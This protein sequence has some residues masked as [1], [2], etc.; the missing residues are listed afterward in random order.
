MISLGGAVLASPLAALGQERVWRLGWLDPN[1]A[2]A[3]GQ[4]Y[5]N[6]DTF[7]K[8]LADLGYVE[9]RNY[10]VESRFADTDNSRL[11]ALAKDLVARGVD[12]IVTIGTP[13]VAAAKSA[14]ATIPIVMAGSAD[15]VEHGLVATLRRPGGNVTGV[16]HSPGPEFAGKCLEL[17]KEAASGIARVGILWDSSGLHEGLSLDAQRASAA[18]LGL[19]LLPH[20][21]KDVRSDADFAAILAAMRGEGADS[22]FVFPNFVNEKYGREIIAFASVNGLPAMYQDTWYTS[23]GG[24]ISYYTN[25][26]SLRRAAAVYVD[27][28]M[29]GAKPGEL[30]VEEPT[31]FELSVNLKAA[32]ALGLA[33]PQSILARADEV[34]E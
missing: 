30:P 26:A 2:P 15:P 9:G 1:P 22:L 32:K 13:T 3:A 10:I 25:W 17:L 18:R 4:S 23:I 20:D 29:R 11:P 19:A 21:V 27:K 7:K 24:L 8:A 16:T 12:I 5:A 14:T 28:I 31:R 34:I 6:L 33:I